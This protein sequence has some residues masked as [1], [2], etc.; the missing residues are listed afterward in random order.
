MTTGSP[1]II[2]SDILNKE[3]TS[4]NLATV[5]WSL[6]F[7]TIKIAITKARIHPPPPINPYIFINGS[8]TILGIEFP[9]PLA[10]IFC[11]NAS[12]IGALLIGERIDDPWIPN[13]HNKSDINCKKIN[14]GDDKTKLL[15]GLEIIAAI[16]SGTVTPHIWS[17]PNTTIAKIVIV[18][19]SG[20]KALNDFSIAGGTFSGILIL[21]HWIDANLT[22]I[23]VPINAVNNE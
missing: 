21:K 18:I 1:N 12:N 19:N 17:S 16:K 20:I 3:G 13:T 15:K 5:L 11:V 14:P 22:K 10:A 8:V 9:A 7:D 2:G 4:P 23:S 6:R